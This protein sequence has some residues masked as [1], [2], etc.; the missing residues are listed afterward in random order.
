MKLLPWALH[1]HKLVCCYVFLLI[2]TIVWI[3]SRKYEFYTWGR[4]FHFQVNSTEIFISNFTSSTICKFARQRLHLRILVRM[5]WVLKCQNPK[6]ETEFQSYWKFM[7]NLSLR[8]KDYCSVAF[9]QKQWMKVFHSVWQQWSLRNS[10][11]F[12]YIDEN[13]IICCEIQPEVDFLLIFM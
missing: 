8:T 3:W 7:G 11:F 13:L 9:V 12:I 4:K 6:T 2:E 5:L 10:N 1:K